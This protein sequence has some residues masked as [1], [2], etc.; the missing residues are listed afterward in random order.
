MEI[1]KGLPE[2]LDRNAPLEETVYHDRR[3]YMNRILVRIPPVMDGTPLYW[4]VRPINAD[5]EGLAPFS[6]PMEVR[7]TMRLISRNAPYPK[8]V[9]RGNGAFLLYPV[10]SYTGNPGASSY[11]VEVTKEYPEN[12]D[13]AR[14]SRYRVWSEVTTL[15]NVYDEQPRLGTYYWRVRGIGS[16]G[17]PVGVWSLP[18]RYEIRRRY[19][20]ISVSSVTASHRAG[21][22]STTVHP[23]SP[24]AMCRIWTFLP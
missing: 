1:F 22:T 14:P 20:L 18:E 4:R 21:D 10:Y 23:I 3:I 17:E 5:W 13:D 12:I 19:I 15:S 16:D 6:A 2:H 24:T 8:A 7:S 11:E 9:G